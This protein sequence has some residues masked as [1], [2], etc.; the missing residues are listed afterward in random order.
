MASS[1]AA[2]FSLKGRSYVVTG[3]A[4]GIGFSI[5]KDIAESGGNVAVIDLRDSPLEDVYGLAK[6]FNVKV[7]YFQADV[8]NEASL[9][10]AFEKAVQSLG[11][12][13]GL[14]TAAGI[15]IDKPFVDQTW[16][17]VSKVL[18][19]NS[20]GSFFAAQLFVKHLQL[21]R[22]GGSIVFIASITAH[23]NLP[24]YRM[25]GYN[26]SKGGIKILSQVL[27]SELAP[28]NIRVN[29][30]SP[31]F[32][33]TNQTR[34]ARENTTQ[35]CGELMQTAPPLGRI[36]V[37]EEVSPAVVFLL[38]EAAAYVTGADLLVSGGIHTGRGG[39]YDMCRK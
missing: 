10:T 29:S 35:A 11:K 39:D 38:S 28:L 36:G 18:E 25:S 4:M 23:I 37:P 22:T 8:S 24:G 7:Y 16:S 14:V 20:L 17:E 13:D 5:A 26:V 2:K 21:Q 32:I 1:I 31:A 34:G 19:V 33:E 6:Q 12:I 9:T 30:V 3:G 27:S 15:A